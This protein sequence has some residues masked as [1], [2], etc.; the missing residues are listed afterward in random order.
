LGYLAI[1]VTYALVDGRKVDFWPPSIHA[2]VDG[3]VPI[4]K[5]HRYLAIAQQLETEENAKIK[6][7]EKFESLN[8]VNMQLE[9]KNT[10]LEKELKAK[11]YPVDTC[12]KP[13]GSVGKLQ[14]YIKIFNKEKT[15]HGHDE[16]GI[17]KSGQWLISATQLAKVESITSSW[18]EKRYGAKWSYI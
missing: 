8:D 15:P 11:I 5:D 6:L 16:D 14:L 9:A 2:K 4:E 12:I 17:R 18:R 10:T 1:I 7:S 13:N 3:T